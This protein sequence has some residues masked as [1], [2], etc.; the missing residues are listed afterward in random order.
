MI[1]SYEGINVRKNGIYLSTETVKKLDKRHKYFEVMYDKKHKAILLH[2][3]DKRTNT[4]DLTATYKKVDETKYNPSASVGFKDQ[5]KI[6]RGRYQ[7][8]DHGDG[9]YIFEK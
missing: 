6:M 4:S 9:K 7:L 1:N 3:K 8:V 5:G 2:G